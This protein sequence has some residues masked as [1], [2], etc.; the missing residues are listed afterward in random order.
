[1]MIHTYLYEISHIL[2]DYR[3]IS[4]LSSLSKI[5]Q[6][7]IYQQLYVYFENSN[8]FSKGQYGFRKGH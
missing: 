8:L 3:P 1:M 2:T 7:G 5:F 6:Q 4:F